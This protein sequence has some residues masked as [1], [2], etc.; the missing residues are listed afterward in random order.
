MLLL[1]EAGKFGDGLGVKQSGN[2][3]M[4]VKDA[5]DFGK[6]TGGQERVS[7]QFEIV[8]IAADG[9]SGEDVFPDSSQCFFRFGLRSGK[10]ILRREL[11]RRQRCL[12]DT[13]NMNL[14]HFNIRLRNKSFENLK[15]VGEYLADGLR[16]VNIRIVF[17]LGANAFLPLNHPELQFEGNAKTDGWEGQ[18]G[19]R[20]L[21]ARLKK[22]SLVKKIKL[23]D[24]LATVDGA[25]FV[26]IDQNFERQFGV[27]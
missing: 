8:L 15:I 1:N 9:T 22:S 10:F 25:H 4:D 12:S 2:W 3:K 27:A 26:A 21:L 24:W 18:D 19:Q 17:E 16:I 20:P 14:V 11:F 13:G 5:I 6:K 23:E 7:A